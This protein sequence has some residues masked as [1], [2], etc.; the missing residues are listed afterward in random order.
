MAQTFK[1]GNSVYSLDQCINGQSKMA[2]YD[3]LAQIALKPDL[4]QDA[5]LCYNQYSI[6]G[7]LSQ[8][9]AKLGLV[10]RKVK[11]NPY[12]WVEYCS[13][14]TNTI[15]VN[16]AVAAGAAG[17]S[18]TVTLNTSSMS[19]NGM[20]SL[21]KAGYR[22][23]LKENRQGFNITAVNKTTAGAHT[24]TLQPLN[25]EVIDLT[26]KASYTLLVDSMRM[27]VKGDTN[28]IVSGGIVQ[29]P[30]TLRKSY[31]QK[32]EDGICLHEDELDGY[33][34][35]VDFSVLRGIDPITRKA[36]YMWCL[37]Q[38][39]NQ[40]LDKILASRI[41][42]TLFNIR[43]DVKQEGFDGM[44]TTAQKSGAFN[45]GYD[46]GN[47][48]SLKYHLFGMIKSLNKSN[49]SNE[50]MLLHDLGFAMDWSEAFADLIKA[51]GQNLN[52]RLF[53]DG[54]EG[55]MNFK[56]YEFRD[57]E[58]YGYKF[59]TYKMDAFDASRFGS[60][61]ENFA[62]ALP[63]QTYKDSAGNVVPPVNYTYIEGCEPYKQ[64]NMWVDDARPRGCR[65]VTVYGKDQYGMEVHCA[66]RLGTFTRVK[67]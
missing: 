50:Y 30:P 25:N 58:A 5:I 36:V 18:V 54:G 33:A 64:K 28:C 42:N 63:A 16:K 38:V 41:V 57:F 51:T 39:Q 65:N 67:C 48:V 66:S 10:N 44:V 23:Y 31:V 8:I 24:I 32:F 13:D 53:G 20:F 26:K 35:D 6:E 46:V 56:H 15:C 19:Q 29:N 3:P 9:Q 47:G 22:A 2:F 61:L 49:G 14:F 59:R 17:A 11:T 7:L 62:L 34:Y 52:F 45:R 60:F 40:L 12:Y 27:Y 37:T 43:D 21:P 55:V 1:C 4:R